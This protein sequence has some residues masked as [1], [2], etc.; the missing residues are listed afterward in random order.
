VT[1]P[2]RRTLAAALQG[3]H[4]TV[5]SLEGDAHELAWLRAVGLFEGQGVTVLRR[6]P[7]SGPLHVRVSSGGEFAVDRAIA[8]HIEVGEQEASR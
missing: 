4:C 6:A 1:N 5:R 7:F 8:D 2:R 3:E